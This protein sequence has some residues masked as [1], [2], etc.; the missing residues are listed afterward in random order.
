[1]SRLNAV[2]WISSGAVLG[3][4]ARWLVNL[5]AVR[6]FGPAFPWGTLVVNLGGCLAIGTVATLVGAR[7]VPRP[8]ELRLFLVVGFLGSLTTF[9]SFAWETH[10]LIESAAWGRALLNVAGSVVGGLAGVRLGI[11]LSHGLSD[12]F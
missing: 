9:S 6:W 7:L 11:L 10:A 2:L 12:F 5:A 1:M 4:N 3:A 8:E